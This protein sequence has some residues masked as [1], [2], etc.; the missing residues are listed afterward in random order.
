MLLLFSEFFFHYLNGHFWLKIVEIGLLK[1]E[2]FSYYS[3]VE[4]DLFTFTV[5]PPSKL[6]VFRDSRMILESIFPVQREVFAIG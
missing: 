4:L 6:N 5:W 2:N 3:L 1:Y